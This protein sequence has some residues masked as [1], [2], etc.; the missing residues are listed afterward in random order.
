MLLTC[1]SADAQLFKKLFR[2]KARTEQRAASTFDGIDDELQLP[3]VNV[4]TL[5]DNSNNRNAFLGIPLGIKAERF[6]KLLSEQG[7]TERK[8]DGPQTGKSYIYAG[9][10]Y[11]APAVVQLAVSERT[12]RVYAVDVQEDTQYTKQTL[13]QRFAALKK[14]LV[15]VYGRGYVDNQGEAY[16]IETRLGTVS[17]HSERNSGVDVY[18]VGFALDDAKAYRMAYEEMEDKE[19]ETAPRTIENGLAPACCHTDLVGLGVLLQGSKSI[20]AAQQVLTKYDYSLGKT[21]A[22]ALTASFVLGDYRVTATLPRRRQT[23]TSVTLTANDSQ[24]M[25]CRDLSTYGFTSADQT[26]WQQG[27][28]K[29]TVTADKQGRVVLIVKS[30]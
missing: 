8:G 27:K 21:T 18:S 11:G 3:M 17:M 5:A 14:Q 19:Y 30:Y 16:T 9:S 15:S 28:M 10:V 1:E 26:T 20:K 4:T 23:V 7:F 6:E 2:K 13:A 12:A 22:K 25:V 29:A 24:E